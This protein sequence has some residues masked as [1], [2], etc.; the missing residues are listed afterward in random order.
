MSP[1]T[2]SNIV[3]ALARLQIRSQPATLHR[4]LS[5]STGPGPP[6]IRACKESGNRE[7]FSPLD[8]ILDEQPHPGQFFA[9]KVFLFFAN[10]I[11]LPIQM[12]MSGPF[13]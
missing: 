6:E 3:S 8:A 9:G 4:I 1:W 12:F 10:Y 5:P 11:L 2:G 7:A 13:R